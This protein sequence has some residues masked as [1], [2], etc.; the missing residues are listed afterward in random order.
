MKRALVGFAVGL[1]VALAGGAPT[2]AQSAAPTLK[3]NGATRTST[4]GV[5]ALSATLSRADGT[6]LPDQEVSFYQQ[7][8]LF[9]PRDALLGSAATDSGG[10]AVLLYQAA[11]RGRQT[12]KATFGGSSGVGKAEASTAIDVRDVV[13]PYEPDAEPL[14]SLRQWLPVALT[15][16]V[17]A[18][19]A[20]VL[21]IAGTS[22]LRIRTR[23]RAAR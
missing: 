15:S 11:T 7:V 2:A 18:V 22:I 13:D 6:P 19:W 10:V 4:R 16:V 1:V 21:G 14:A 8:D 23:G 20:L 12:I 3:V 17:V 5:L 9:G